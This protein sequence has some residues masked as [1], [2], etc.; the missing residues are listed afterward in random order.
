MRIETKH[1]RQELTMISWKHNNSLCM[2]AISD[3]KIAAMVPP[4][5]SIA[6]GDIARQTPMTENMTARLLRHAMTM[7]LF[8]EPEPGMVAHTAASRTLTNPA[9]NDWLRAGTEE[10]WPAATKVRMTILFG[11]R[12][13][14]QELTFAV[15]RW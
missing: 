14:V 5:G 13:A 11:V 10:M 15:A 4:Q 2:Q 8:R 9:A 7:R 6:F 1:V 3:F 12:A